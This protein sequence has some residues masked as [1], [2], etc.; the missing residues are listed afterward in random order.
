MKVLI[1]AHGILGFGAPHF[2]LFNKYFSKFKY[3]SGVSAAIN[4]NMLK[5]LEQQAPTIGTVKL[6]AAKLA[7]LILKETSADDEVY[8]VAHSMGGLDARLALQQNSAVR[9]RVIALAT[10]GTP[11]EGSQVADAIIS[12]GPG[13]NI[14]KR[15]LELLPSRA[16]GLLDLTTEA[17]T[18]FNVT[19]IDQSNIAYYAIAGD[20]LSGNKFS[21]LLKL[22]SRIGH[23]EN[24]QSDGVVIVDSAERKGWVILPRWS[25]D[26]LAQIGWHWDY[27]FD[28]SEHIERYLQLISRIA[29]IEYEQLKK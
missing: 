20:A 25:V 18:K 26:H 21:S 4:Q 7:E 10:I 23:I 5:V 14:P 13:Q 9:E 1:L 12:A 3:F 17:C 8:I 19:C 28:A 15:I 11:H 27:L 22:A 16:Q 24:R 2:F 6:R 29:N